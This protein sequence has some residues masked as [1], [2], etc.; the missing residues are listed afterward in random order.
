MTIK[1]IKKTKSAKNILKIF[2]LLI[3]I[4]FVVKTIV[5]LE[6]FKS[7]LVLIALI[8]LILDMATKLTRKQKS[9]GFFSKFSFA[10]LKAKDNSE[11]YGEH[12]LWIT[13]SMLIIYWFTAPQIHSL[14][15][16]TYGIAKSFSYI[17]GKQ[18]SKSKFYESTTGETAAFFVIG[19]IV[20]IYIAGI[21]DI[22]ALG[23]FFIIFSWLC[24]SMADARRGLVKFNNP[25]LSMSVF[26]VILVI[27]NGVWGVL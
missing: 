16:L 14:C 3:T 17:I 24:A 12:I 11:S 27:L 26:T 19:L 7:I 15:F 23:L 4:S 1:T 20:L 6:V 10:S 9:G 21:T 2:Y 22:K 8:S 25:A 13:L 18:I 5:G